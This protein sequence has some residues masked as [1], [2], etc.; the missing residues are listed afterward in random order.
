MLL[1][2]RQFRVKVHQLIDGCLFALGLWLAWGIRNYWTQFGPEGVNAIFGP[3]FAHKIFGLKGVDAIAPFQ[4][5]LWLFLV[6]IPMTPLVLEWH[7]FYE[8]PIFS[9]VK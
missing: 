3:N 4:D 9:P 5:Y 6:V 1:R 2:D 8:R 7:G